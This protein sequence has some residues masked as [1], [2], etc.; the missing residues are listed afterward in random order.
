VNARTY[1]RIAALAAACA[2]SVAPASCSPEPAPKCAA[3]RGAF[4]A[5]YT[6]TS[7]TGD[8]S[9]LVGEILNVQSYNPP[10]S[11]TDQ[12]PNY[13]IAS[14]AIEPS[15]ITNALAGGGMDPNAAD[16]PYGIGTFSS[17]EPGSDGFCVAP[18]LSLAHL[19]LPSVDAM[20]NACPPAAAMPAVDMQYAFANV[21]VYSTAAAL[22]TELSADLTYTTTDPSG[23][24]CTAV[25]HVRGVYPAVSCGGSPP[26]TG[27]DSG[28]TGDDS[29]AQDSGGDDASSPSGDDAGAAAD[30]AGDDAS[31]ESD[32]AAP[33]PA[34]PSGPMVPDITLCSPYPNPS[35][36]LATGSGLDPDY[37]ISCDPNLL[38]CVLSKEPPSLK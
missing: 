37:A 11:P 4:A 20:P 2:V 26:A 23:A 15:A 33:A 29:A 27:D 24:T 19:V 13:D 10:H 22:G 3:A 25:Y 32:C 17:S 1:V 31:A 5:T 12:T 16:L 34:A 36:G 35:A 14:I 38:L 21:R 8:C 7:G 28:S 18:S 30:D 6:L 9:T